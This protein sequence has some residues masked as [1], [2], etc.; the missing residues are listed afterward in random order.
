M[1]LF[2]EK[3]IVA[4]E[5]MPHSHRNASLLTGTKALTNSTL[6]AGLVIAR[7][8][9]I[10]FLKTPRLATA[11]FSQGAESSPFNLSAASVVKA[12]TGRVKSYNFCG[13]SVRLIKI[14]KPTKAPFNAFTLFG[15][16]GRACLAQNV[17]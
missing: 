9:A 2:P 15:S 3:P 5:L 14:E 16:P 13:I 12:M 11:A 8:K 7:I 17:R 4:A 6:Q 1:R 10:V